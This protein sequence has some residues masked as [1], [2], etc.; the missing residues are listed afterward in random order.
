MEIYV[1]E[2]FTFAVSLVPDAVQ[3]LSCRCLRCAQYAADRREEEEMC[4]HLIS[5]AKHDEL[6]TANQQ[7]QKILNILR[8]KH[9]LE[10]VDISWND[11]VSGTL[12]VFTEQKHLVSKL[13]VPRMSS[14]G[15]ISEDVQTLGHLLPKL[16]SLE[17]FDLSINRNI[18]NSLDIIAQRLKSTSSLKVLKLHSCGLTPK[19]TLDLS[20]NKELGGG[21]EDVPAQLALLKNLEVLDLHQCSLTADDVASLTHIIPLLSNL[22]ELDLSSN[23]TVGSSSGILLSRLPFLPALKSLLIKSCA[24]ESETFTAFA[25]ASVYSPAL[26]ILNLSWNKCVAGNLELLLHTLKLAKSLQ[27]LR[28]NNC[29]LVTEDLVLLAS[30]MQTSHLAELQKPDLSYSDSICDTGWDIFCQN[31]CFLKQLTDLDISL[32]PWSSQGTRR[33]AVKVSHE[34]QLEC[35]THSHRRGIQLDH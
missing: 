9:D 6:V 7:K 21:F 16:Q 24:L 28:L 1:P 20:C 12:H 30:A 14:C 10:E 2:T 19:S 17:V 22:Q 23:R 33:L 35:F 4:D 25:E 5:A 11:F 32:W 26:E 13:K 3:I 27:G 29:T 34:E 31:L 18:G 8:N 15:F